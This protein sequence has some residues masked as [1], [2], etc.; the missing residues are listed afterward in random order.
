MRGLVE[1]RETWVQKWTGSTIS[2]KKI[3]GKRMS[4]RGSRKVA[5]WQKRTSRGRVKG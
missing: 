1:M 4:D 5:Y 3:T 2:K